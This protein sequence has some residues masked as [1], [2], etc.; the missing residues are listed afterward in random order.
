MLP[1]NSAIIGASVAFFL[2]SLDLVTH[3]FWKYP[4]LIWALPLLGWAMV[5]AYQRWGGD[6]SLGTTAILQRMHKPGEPVPRRMAYFVLFSTLATHLGG[7]SAGREGTAVQM[8]GSLASIFVRLLKLKQAE[9]RL[10]LICGVAA[11]FGAVFGT[12]LAGA[13]FAVEF[14]AVGRLEH[15]SLPPALAAAYLADFVARS[16]GAVHMQFAVTSLPMHPALGFQMSLVIMAL[17]AGIAFG[18]LAR[19]FTGLLHRFAAFWQRWIKRPNLRPVA[20][21][22][23][24]IALTYLIGSR[25]FLGLGVSSPNR[26][27]PSIEAFF[28]SAGAHP[29]AWLGKLIFTTITLSCGFRGGEV[30]P[31]FFIGAAA[32]HAMALATGLPA[33]YLSALGF[34]AVFG[35]AAQTPLASCIMGIELFG[36][37]LAPGF[38]VACF[39]AYWASGHIGIYRG[40]LREINKPF[41]TSHL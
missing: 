9:A 25:A 23:L 1:V 14:M 40:Q 33:D 12:P 15:A 41:A 11:G 29:W 36:S 6:A 26:L 37:S 21:G 31:L 17:G 18:W 10:L 5:T 7:G 24:I 22:L 32:G 39:A 28:W 8:G 16:C 20:G 4:L 30:T 27:D 19:L 2:W 34:V 35:A 3:W 13:I 38:A